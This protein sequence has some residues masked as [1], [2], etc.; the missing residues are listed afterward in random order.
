M[1][2][3]NRLATASRLPRPNADNYTRRIKPEKINA[4]DW[5]DWIEWIGLFDRAGA[6]NLF[7]E[8]NR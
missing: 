8:K 1:P 7:T 6:H 3:T 2:S 5:I 4:I